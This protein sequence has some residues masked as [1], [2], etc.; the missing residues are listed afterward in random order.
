MVQYP[1]Q[2]LG[3]PGHMVLARRGTTATHAAVIDHN[4]LM[5]RG[6]VMVDAVPGS[7]GTGESP[8]QQC[9]GATLSSHFVIDFR[10]ARSNYWHA[11]ALETAET[12]PQTTPFQ[13]TPHPIVCIGSLRGLLEPESMNRL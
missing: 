9:R 7:H 1:H 12:T 13:R 10:D 2:I 11:R 5:V 3:H 8:H 6:E 4:R